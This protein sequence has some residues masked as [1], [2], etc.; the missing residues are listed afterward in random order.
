ML[1]ASQ[2]APIDALLPVTRRE[3]GLA[4]RGEAAKIAKQ[5]FS[6]SIGIA[7]FLNHEVSKKDLIACTSKAIDQA[8]TAGRNTILFWGQYRRARTLRSCG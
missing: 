7:L 8:K 4:I 1:T 3:C 5:Q 6:V 2:M